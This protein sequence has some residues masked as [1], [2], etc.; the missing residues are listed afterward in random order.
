MDCN[1]L[2]CRWTKLSHAYVFS[3][4]AH[5]LAVITSGTP[6]DRVDSYVKEKMNILHF[7]QHE[8]VL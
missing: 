2:S 6:Q 7:L 4:T 1:R 8:Y 5:F 3:T